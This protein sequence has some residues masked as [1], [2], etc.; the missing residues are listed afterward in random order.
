[1]GVEFAYI[2]ISAGWL[3][4]KAQKKKGW[5]GVK[6]KGTSAPGE[7]DKAKRASKVTHLRE[8]RPRGVRLAVA[9]VGS[10]CPL[11]LQSKVAS[12]CSAPAPGSRL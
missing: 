12:L 6:R 11:G 2:S 10:V 1:M 9:A 4:S 8:R 7:S 3:E 5:S